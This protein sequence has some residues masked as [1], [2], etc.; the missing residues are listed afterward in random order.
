MTSTPNVNLAIVDPNQTGKTFTLD[1]MIAA[2]DAVVGAIYSVDASAHTSP[3]TIP[4]DTADEPLGTK[5][6]L[7]FFMMKVTGT[8]SADWTAIFP[9]GPSKFFIVQNN[10]SGAYQVKARTA[11]GTGISVGPGETTFAIL[12]GADVESI[13]FSGAGGSAPYDIGNFFN[14]QPT[15]SEVIMRFVAGRTI[16]F[17]ANF[18][19]SQF[20]AG[21]AATA[22]SVFTITRNGS[23][24]GTITVGASGTSGTWTSSGGGAV[25]YVAGDVGTIVAPSS[26]DATLANLDWTLVGTR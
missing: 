14:G 5:T 10:T 6:A 13:G 24:V 15:S 25:T 22:S 12:N 4:Y 16:T 11:A 21:V 20:K 2:I 19:G 7:R 26:P 23:N 1:L 8:L 18:V 3:Y 17:A 9:T